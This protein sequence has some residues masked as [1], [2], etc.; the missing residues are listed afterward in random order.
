MKGKNYNTRNCFHT[1]TLDSTST[2]TDCAN[3][4]MLEDLK[5]ALINPVVTSEDIPWITE[6]EMEFL[7]IGRPKLEKGVR[8]NQFMDGLDFELYGNLGIDLFKLKSGIQWSEIPNNDLEFLDHVLK[9]KL[10]VKISYSNILL[11][12][13]FPEQTI[14]HLSNF[15]RTGKNLFEIVR[16][17]KINI[18][19]LKNIAIK[20]LPKELPMDQDLE[21]GY[22]DFLEGTQTE[23]RMA[24]ELR[25]YIQLVIPDLKI[26]LPT[27]KRSL[28]P[29]AFISE[30]QWR[31][32]IYFFDLK[33]SYDFSLIVLISRFIIANKSPFSLSK[34]LEIDS[35]MEKKGHPSTDLEILDIYNQTLWLKRIDFGFLLEKLITPSAMNRLRP[36]YKKALNKT[37]L[38]RKTRSSIN[39]YTKAKL[40]IIKSSE[41]I[42]AKIISNQLP[43][44]ASG[45]RIEIC[46]LTGLQFVQYIEKAKPLVLVL[47]RENSNETKQILKDTINNNKLENLSYMITEKV[48]G[49]NT[50]AFLLD[51]RIC[52]AKFDPADALTFTKCLTDA[53]AKL[54]QTKQ[55]DKGSGSLDS[56][57]R[58]LMNNK[59]L[60]QSQ[61][62]IAHRLWDACEK[63][64][65]ISPEL[66]S[67]TITRKAACTCSEE[68]ITTEYE[69]LQ[70]HLPKSF[71]DIIQAI[72]Q[73]QHLYTKA[74]IELLLRHP[75]ATHQERE[76]VKM[77]EKSIFDSIIKEILDMDHPIEKLERYIDHH[78]FSLKAKEK[79]ELRMA[80]TISQDIPILV[81]LG[82]IDPTVFT[83]TNLEYAIQNHALQSVKFLINNG[84]NFF[85]NNHG[86]LFHVSSLMKGG[87]SDF[88]RSVVCE[89]LKFKFL[90]LN[91]AS[92]FSGSYLNPEENCELCSIITSFGK[93]ITD[94]I[95]ELIQEELYFEFL[96]RSTTDNNPSFFPARK[97]EIDSFSLMKHIESLIFDL[98]T[99]KDEAQVAK[100][101]NILCELIDPNIETFPF[102]QNLS[103]QLQSLHEL[104]TQKQ[105]LFRDLKFQ[106]IVMSIRNKTL[107]SGAALSEIESCPIDKDQMQE[108]RQLTITAKNTFSTFRDIYNVT[109]KKSLLNYQLRPSNANIENGSIIQTIKSSNDYLRQKELADSKQEYRLLSL[110]LKRDAHNSNITNSGLDQH[111]KATATKSLIM[112]LEKE[113]ADLSSNNNNQQHDLV[114][115]TKQQEVVQLRSEL[116]KLLK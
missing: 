16:K 71:V 38:Q 63:A 44:H 10:K 47:D 14:V 90:G 45:F 86:N 101:V 70:D 52:D 116:L 87:A 72:L 25:P 61:I 77:E 79:K 106:E 40:V 31:E 51:G 55:K 18:A 97:K 85:Q 91:I 13:D 102:L 46:E 83:D 57:E 26:A 84:V 3:T 6:Q 37:D 12:G 35:V 19:N 50:T 66:G 58:K 43:V 9:D 15:C 100:K 65:G 33:N 4:R 17:L 32:L 69:S 28:L 109:E 99:Q 48:S 104:K 2:K 67:I 80:A 8:L 34:V 95:F 113:I 27:E 105:A 89:I 5:Q 107:I 111:Q 11:F 23:K 1:R 36:I 94:H 78:T 115:K 81:F 21:I 110:Q 114:I 54:C 98:A 22:S 74:E 73:N 92:I 108:L 39:K 30:E 88:Q 76:F 62:N 93:K 24:L 96:I 68:S 64:R 75:E 59:I 20:D 82:E 29:K 49:A 42:L 41:T 60:N 7:G 53:F 112:I 56:F 103:N